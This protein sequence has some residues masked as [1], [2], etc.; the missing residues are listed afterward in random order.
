LSIRPSQRGDENRLE[1]EI[2][3][4]RK[5]R[6]RDD[7]TDDA[8]FYYLDEQ[9]RQHTRHFPVMYYDALFQKPELSGSG[10]KIVGA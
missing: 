6:G 3:T 7:E 5:S 4:L 8:L 10:A 9:S 2:E 1:W